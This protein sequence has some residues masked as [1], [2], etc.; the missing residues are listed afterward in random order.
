VPS[1]SG[2]SVLRMRLSSGCLSLT[3][4][5]VVAHIIST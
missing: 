4:S 3:V 5:F 1:E 2:R